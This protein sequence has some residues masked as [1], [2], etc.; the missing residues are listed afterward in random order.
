MSHEI[1]DVRQLTR[2]YVADGEDLLQRLQRREVPD[3]Q[4][5]LHIASWISTVTDDIL[6]LMPED[7][8]DFSV[9][10][11]M[12]SQY[13]RTPSIIQPSAENDIRCVLKNVRIAYDCSAA[14]ANADERNIPPANMAAMSFDSLKEIVEYVRREVIERLKGRKDGRTQKTALL[15]IYARI[16]LWAQ[17]MVKLD[18]IEDCLALAGALRA[19]L[20]HYVDLRLIEAGSVRNDLEKYFSFQDVERWRKARNVVQTKKS[21][22]LANSKE[23]TPAEEYLNAPKNK[24]VNIIKLRESVWG[25]T[26]GGKV[27]NPKHW[28]DMTLID[29]VKELGDLATTNMYLSSYYYCN[30]LVHSMYLDTINNPKAVPLLNWYFYDLAWKMLR[31]ATELVNEVI[32]VV[33]EDDLR[34]QFKGIKARAFKRFFGEMVKA[35]RNP[36]SKEG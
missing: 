17:S 28:T 11:A 5:P 12:K 16:Y 2:K 27:V 25:K 10:S 20:E 13:A 19:I 26:A 29:R 8:P 30:W 23:T 3:S 32:G 4:L 15:H 18:R 35:G 22:G 6:A 1:N 24:E 34:S 33:P 21:L 9:L 31:K 7:C 14:V 36:T